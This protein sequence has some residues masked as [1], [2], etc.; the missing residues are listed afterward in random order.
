MILIFK[1]TAQRQSK[2][3]NS[4]FYGFSKVL[5]FLFTTHFLLSL[6]QLTC[7]QKTT[8]ILSREKQFVKR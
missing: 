8:K 1:L 4:F 7:V 3:L 5:G 2:Q 6:K